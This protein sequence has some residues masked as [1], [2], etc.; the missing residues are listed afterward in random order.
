MEKGPAYQ[1]SLIFA[2]PAAGGA[3]RAGP[4]ILAANCSRPGAL[5]KLALLERLLKETIPHHPLYSIIVP[6]GKIRLLKSFLSTQEWV[7]RA[8]GS[9]DVTI[10]LG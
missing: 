5:L 4:A 8:E 9:T 10:A 6:N 1:R 3:R 7:P 2:Q